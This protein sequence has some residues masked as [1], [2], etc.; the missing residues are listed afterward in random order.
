[1]T[2]SYLSKKHSHLSSIN[3]ETLNKLFAIEKEVLVIKKLHEMQKVLLSSGAYSDNNIERQDMNFDRVGVP[4]WERDIVTR[5]W[6]IKRKYAHK[7]FKD[8]D[9]LIS[10]MEKELNGKEIQ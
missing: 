2:K 10:E 3:R 1:M 5:M 6:N 4:Q 7:L 8:M 9:L